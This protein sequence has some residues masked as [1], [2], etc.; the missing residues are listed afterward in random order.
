MM[1]IHINTKKKEIEMIWCDNPLVISMFDSL[2]LL[3]TFS[4]L[5]SPTIELI[6]DKTKGKLIYSKDFKDYL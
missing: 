6:R 5:I 1:Y 2:L 3:L 4:L